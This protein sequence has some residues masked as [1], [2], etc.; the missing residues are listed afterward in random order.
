[1]AQ[2]INTFVNLISKDLNI[3][4]KS[5][6]TPPQGMDS[7]V[8]FLVDEKN[9]RYVVKVGSGTE[10]DVEAYRIIVKNKLN[11]PVPKVYF[12]KKYEDT[13]IAVFEEIPYPMLESIAPSE[14]GK[15]VPSMIDTLNII[16]SIKSE[17]TG[18]LTDKQE[19]RTWGEFHLSKFNGTDDYL[20]W[21]KISK[22]ESLDSGLILS[23]VEKYIKSFDKAYIP[24]NEYSLLHTDYNQRNLFVNPKSKKISGII[25]WGESM[26]GDPLYDFARV[27]MLLWHFNLGKEV[28]DEYYGLMNYSPEQRKLHDLYWT[29]RVIEYLAYYSEESTEFN[30]SRIVLHQ[31]FLRN[32]EW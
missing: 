1:M 17:R 11:L 28:V 25:D 7:N 6:E 14:M 12:N 30:D 19:K 10:S 24:M 20:D 26:F 29:S 32:L 21:G 2:E 8:F 9:N 27:R 3:N 18:Y 23:S 15:Y 13:F 22:R 5:I 31:K 16:H 4:V